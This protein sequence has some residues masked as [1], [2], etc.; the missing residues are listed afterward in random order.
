MFEQEGHFLTFLIY[1]SSIC[2][3]SC[4]FWLIV[5]DVMLGVLIVY[6]VTG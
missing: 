6:K 5:D 2:W 3:I 4:G 1:R